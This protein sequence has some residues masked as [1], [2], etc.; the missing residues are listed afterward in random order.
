MSHVRFLAS[1]LLEGREAGGRGDALAEGYVASV[2]TQVG[3]SPV[4]G[5]S[6]YRQTFTVL[7]CELDREGTFL[8]LEQK[9][10]TRIFRL[11]REVFCSLNN[12]GDVR[13]EAPVVFV[14][15]GITAP[16]YGYDDYA[17]VDVRGK[18]VLVLNH[19]PAEKGEG[20]KFKGRAPTRYMNPRT[21][22]KIAREHGALA[23]VVVNDKLNGHPDLDVTLPQR[24]GEML[25][26]PYLCLLGQ[27]PELPLFYATEEVAEIITEDTGVD[28]WQR[29]ARIDR[30]LKPASSILP[31]KKVVLEVKLAKVE[32]KQ[33]ANVIG[34]VKGRDERLAHEFIV[35]GAHHD[36]LGFDSQGRVYT[37]ADDNAS[38]TAG[39]LEAARLLNNGGKRP[40]RSVL[41]VSFCG[42]EKGLLGSSYFISHPPVPL[43]SIRAMIDLDMIGRNNMDKDE[44]A[45]MFI[46][47]TSA[48]TPYLGKVARSVA[49]AQSVDLRLAPHLSFRGASDHANFHRTGIPV[50]FYFSGYHGDYHEVT[51][52]VDKIAP[53]KMEEVVRHLAEVVRKLAEAPE[54]KLSFDRSITEEPEKDRFERPY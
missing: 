45:R 29:Q 38:G 41:F 43:R 30:R 7:R 19:E 31:G 6:D 28:V 22:V 15:Y 51:D 54:E 50:M 49:S 26:R 27:Q 5:L 52:R 48:Q 16:E 18:V 10:R 53:A 1:D 46:V 34:V 4:E 14:G 2:F 33:I 8:A 25:A 12:H 24:Y 44:N 42:E 37:G 39:L 17:G 13:V 40:A 20:K 35:V 36:H 3:L 21:K 47:F 23:V 9:G 11:G 32:R